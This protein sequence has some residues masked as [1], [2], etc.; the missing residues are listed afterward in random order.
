LKIGKYNYPVFPIYGGKLGK[1]HGYLN[2]KTEK[3]VD[4][5]FLFY[6]EDGPELSTGAGEKTIEIKR[7]KMRKIVFVTL[8]IGLCSCSPVLAAFNASVRPYVGGSDLR[9][10]LATPVNNEINQQVI[11]DINTDIGKQYQL[12][13][14]ILEPLT[15]SQGV[16]IPQN[17]FFVKGVLGSNRSGTLSVQQELPVSLGR[18]IIYT[19][20]VEGIADSFDLLYILKYPLR[21]PSGSYRGRMAFSLEALNSSEQPVTV[22]LNVSAEVSGEGSVEIKTVNGSKVIS[23]NSTQPDENSGSVLFTIKGDMGSQYRVSQL[24]SAPFISDEGESLAYDAVNFQLSEAK[25]GSGSTPSAPLSNRKEI[26][27]TSSPAGEADSFVVTYSLISPEKQKAGKYR[28]SLKYSVESPGLIQTQE[29]FF[30][31]LEI[32]RIFDLNVTPE[33]GGLIEFRDLKPKESPRQSEVV[34]EVNSNIGRQ[35]QVSQQLSAGL[36]NK[37]G[38]R[39]PPKYFTLKEESQQTKGKLPFSSPAEVREGQMVLFVS[40]PDGSSD[41][42]KIIY[43]LTPSFEITA[44]DYSAR[45]TY[46]ISEI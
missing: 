10:E 41:K 8:I 36:M 44:G 31:E 34:I 26:L 40:D 6:R 33:M 12:I 42:F 30:L 38:T 21:V 15:N 19:S 20:N 35:Y 24:L 22:I 45:I 43:E 23:L 9:F 14:T 3:R 28:N 4:R 46:S 7:K 2:R 32:A 5:F 17:N 13:Q 27:Y 18:T 16:S 11:I 39:I 1:C 37:D 29:D 25:K